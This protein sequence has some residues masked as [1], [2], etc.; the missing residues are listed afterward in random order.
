MEK[1]IKHEDL[2]ERRKNMIS[3]SKEISSF[4]VE[5]VWNAACVE[6]NKFHP[7]TGDE[8]ASCLITLLSHFNCNFLLNIKEIVNLD[9]TCHSLEDLQQSLFNGISAMMNTPKIKNNTENYL[10]EIKKLNYK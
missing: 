7:T 9:S 2:S 4:S 10:G 5:K 1:I 6:L 3:I 8:L